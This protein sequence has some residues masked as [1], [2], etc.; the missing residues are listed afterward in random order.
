MENSPSAKTITR[1]YWIWCYFDLERFKSA[2]IHFWMPK[3]PCGGLGPKVPHGTG[4][5]FTCLAWTGGKSSGMM[6]KWMAFPI[7]RFAFHSSARLDYWITAFSE[8]HGQRSLTP[9]LGGELLTSTCPACGCPRSLKETENS[10][11]WFHCQ[12]GVGKI[13]CGLGLDP[14]S[15]CQ[16]HLR[17]EVLWIRATRAEGAHFRPL[18]FCPGRHPFCMPGPCRVGGPWEGVK[19]TAASK[20]SKF[21]QQKMQEHAK[22]LVYVLECLGSWI[23]WLTDW[24]GIDL[25]PQ[26]D[27][28]RGRKWSHNLQSLKLTWPPQN[29]RKTRRSAVKWPRLVS[30]ARKFVLQELQ[31]FW[32]DPALTTSLPEVE[33]FLSEHVHVQTLEYHLARTPWLWKPRFQCQH[34]RKKKN[35]VS[36]SSSCW[37]SRPQPCCEEKLFRVPSLRGSLDLA[38]SRAVA[39][40]FGQSWASHSVSSSGLSE[41]AACAPA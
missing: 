23:S 30:R 3:V 19:P 32:A 13:T 10:R 39:M 7:L 20:K 6:L 27:W 4:S 26:P 16:L 38:A 36:S 15:T 40:F 17:N 35:R 41:A 31:R 8:T 9:D 14:T 21:P 22:T 25:K 33:G 29:L 28:S 18:G 2:T 11:S 24:D 5:Q 1:G 34:R 12:P 37:S